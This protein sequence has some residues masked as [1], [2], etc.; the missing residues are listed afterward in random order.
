MS[1]KVRPV[2]G[3]SGST[4]SSS[5]LHATAEDMSRT[6]TNVDAQL[7]AQSRAADRNEEPQVQGN[8]L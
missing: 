6:G 5:A 7:D 3:R 8:G 2:Q 1:K 4:P